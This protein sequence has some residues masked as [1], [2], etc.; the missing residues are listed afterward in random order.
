MTRMST[1]CVV[2][3]AVSLAGTYTA[4]STTSLAVRAG[5]LGA[6]AAVPWRTA[7]V[8]ALLTTIRSMRG[9]VASAAGIVTSPAVTGNRTPL[10]R[11]APLA[12]A[13][14]MLA[15]PLIAPGAGLSHGGV[16]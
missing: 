11:T 4:P 5:G 13:G 14:G 10:E 2:A 7:L 8:P 9:L 1:I 15:P 3:I 12:T 16:G 6:A